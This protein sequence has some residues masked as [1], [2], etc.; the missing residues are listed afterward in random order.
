MTLEETTPIFAPS[1]SGTRTVVQVGDAIALTRQLR[2][3]RDMAGVPPKIVLDAT[4]GDS[5]VPEFVSRLSRVEIGDRDG[6]V[7]ATVAGYGI[8]P[9]EGLDMEALTARL[10]A[11]KAKL[12][13]EVKKIEGKLGNERF[14]SKAPAEVV[15]EEREKLERTRA[16]LAELG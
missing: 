10:S 9:S 6:E 1:P 16:E 7:V 11:R 8:L 14:V 4:G 5:D 12:E 2:G 3:W 13:V 15:A